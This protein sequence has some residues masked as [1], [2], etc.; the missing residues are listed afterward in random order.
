[1]PNFTCTV[2]DQN[3]SYLHETS[4]ILLKGFMLFRI[5]LFIF[6]L[7]RRFGRIALM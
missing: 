6:M 5:M 1:M 3:W 4:Y 2:L 7:Y